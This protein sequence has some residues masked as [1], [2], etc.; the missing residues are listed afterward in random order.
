[1]YIY[2]HMYVFMSVWLYAWFFIVLGFVMSF[3]SVFV[4]FHILIFSCLFV[5]ID[6]FCVVGS[7]G[8]TCVCVCCVSRQWLRN[9][10]CWSAFKY[11]EVVIIV[12]ILLFYI[13]IYIFYASKFLVF[14]VPKCVCLNVFERCSKLTLLLAVNWFN[15][16]LDLEQRFHW[17]WVMACGLEF[18]KIRIVNESFSLSN[19]KKF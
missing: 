5:F 6:T 14:L 15:M 4:D 2:I 11:D 19:L 7:V 9:V 10:G 18:S 12:L 13:F 1:M 17:N 8:C 3:R 16:W